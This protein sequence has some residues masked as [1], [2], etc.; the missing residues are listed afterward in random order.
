M[1]VGECEEMVSKVE[2]GFLENFV[3][4]IYMQDCKSG[5]KLRNAL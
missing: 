5:K 1:G 3:S 4:S 2:V